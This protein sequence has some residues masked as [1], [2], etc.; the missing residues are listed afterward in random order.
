[1]AARIRVGIVGATTTVGGSGWGAHAHVP[2]LRALPDYELRAV[3]TAHADTALAAREAFGAELA[4][5]D[6]EDMLARPDIDLVAVVVRVPGHYDLVEAAL[7]AGKRVFC[8]W[9]LGATLAEAES[10]AQLA[11]ERSLLTA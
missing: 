7:H 3:C 8:E 2:A 11:T 1:M 5:H 4:F 10:L 9:P 6:F